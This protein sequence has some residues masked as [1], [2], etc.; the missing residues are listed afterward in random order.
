[1]ALTLITRK[2]DI[3]A[4]VSEG[5]TSAI[6]N[7]PPL[8]VFGGMG[9]Q[10]EKELEKLPSLIPTDETLILVWLESSAKIQ[11]V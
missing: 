11:K 6:L 7:P 3:Y 10:K 5:R 1:M 9:E 8:C 2:K 4:N